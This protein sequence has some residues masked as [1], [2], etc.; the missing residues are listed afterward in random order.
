MQF[1]YMM[2]EGKALNA[3][4]PIQP[5]PASLKPGLIAKSQSSA[6]RA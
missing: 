5:A 1:G 4:D 2:I 3:R 6:Y